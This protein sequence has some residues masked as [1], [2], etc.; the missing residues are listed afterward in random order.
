MYKKYL[1]RKTI[2]FTIIAF[3]FGTSITVGINNLS[4]YS[5]N[6]II[7]IEK[8]NQ[9]NNVIFNDDFDDGDYARWV[10]WQP[11][12]FHSARTYHGLET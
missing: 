12:H 11:F 3:F 5:S 1:L 2:I 7:L 9:N 6:N 8:G 4:S 10:S